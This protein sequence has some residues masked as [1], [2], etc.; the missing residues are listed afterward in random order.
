MYWCNASSA[1]PTRSPRARSQS[2]C[3]RPR[4]DWNEPARREGDRW[5]GR[6]HAHE[7]VVAHLKKL[8][9]PI[10]PSGEQAH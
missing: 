3:R 1:E 7:I 4:L 5:K 6:I 10:G 2:A 8:L 9:E